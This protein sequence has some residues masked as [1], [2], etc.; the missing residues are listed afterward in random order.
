MPQCDSAEMCLL[1]EGGEANASRSLVHGCVFIQYF[2]APAVQDAAERS[3]SDS[4][5]NFKL[6]C[7]G[8]GQRWTTGV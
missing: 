6:R 2:V 4:S 3:P 8:L 1:P 5:G 7:M